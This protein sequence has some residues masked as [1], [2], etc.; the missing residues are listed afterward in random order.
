[1]FR[2]CF[3]FRL[4][5][6]L[7][8]GLLMAGCAS[9]PGNDLAPFGENHR[10][11]MAAQTYSYGDHTPTLSGDKAARIMEAY[12]NRGLSQDAPISDKMGGG[13]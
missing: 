4:L 3:H 1:M 6:T 8:A 9:S 5:I 10:Q 7:A 2:F 12:R 11:T 13:R